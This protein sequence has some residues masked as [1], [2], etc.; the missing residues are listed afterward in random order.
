MSATSKEKDLIK[1]AIR[2]M[3]PEIAEAVRAAF[4]LPEGEGGE[5]G[6]EEGEEEDAPPAPAQS[7]TATA[8]V[9]GPIKPRSGF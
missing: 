8:D 9:H 4:E 2:E 7:Y 3:L 5:E 1:Q 6:G